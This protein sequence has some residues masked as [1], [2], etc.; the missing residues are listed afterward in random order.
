MFHAVLIEIEQAIS[1]ALDKLNKTMLCIQ[2]C[3]NT[4]HSLLNNINL[5]LP[6]A[7]ML[8]GFGVFYA[9]LVEIERTVG[10]AIEHFAATVTK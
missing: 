2:W 1:F 4:A 10:F 6:W 3:V 7:N 8:A 5:N 9:I